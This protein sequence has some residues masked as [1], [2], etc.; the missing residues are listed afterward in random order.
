MGH[1]SVW[2]YQCCNKSSHWLGLASHFSVT[3]LDL[4]ILPKWLDLTR[5]TSENDSNLTL[6]RPQFD[7][8]QR[9]TRVMTF[10]WFASWHAHKVVSL[11]NVEL[12]T[13][14]VPSFNFRW[15]NKKL[16]LVSHSNVN[17]KIIHSTPCTLGFYVQSLRWWPCSWQNILV[18]LQKGNT[19]HHTDLSWLEGE[20]TWLDLT[21]DLSTF[22]LTWY[23]TRARVTCYNT[24]LSCK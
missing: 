1:E 2:L 7:S 20:M 13:M 10:K 23:V 9:V 6:T 19:L 18:R 11:N 16:V 24:G 3:W 21:C 5:V 4:S 17:I 8:S 15:E 12:W 14:I 22:D